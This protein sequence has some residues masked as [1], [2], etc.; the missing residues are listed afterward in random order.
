[1]R[2]RYVVGG[3][4]VVLV[5]AALAVAAT[6]LPAFGHY[7]HAY[8]RVVARSA[9]ADRSATNA[10]VVTTFD[11]RGFDTLGEEFI[12]F[13]SVVGVV[14]LLRRMRRE[15]DGEPAEADPAELEVED[16]V[17]STA[18]RWLGA[19]AVGP[20]AVLAVYII[21][22]GALTPGG[23][24]QGGV[25]LMAAALALA[26]GGQSAVLLR[27][28]RSSTPLEMAEAAGASAFVMIGF[29]GLIAS[30]VFFSNFI[31]KGTHGLLSGGVLP[32]DNIAVGLEVAGALLIVISELFDQRLRRGAG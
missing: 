21:V 4:G 23:G 28:R 1:M 7:S 25:I 9:Q 10:V 3:L 22:H 12:L 18:E 24:F 14:V 15:G 13:I 16:A 30:G 29:G 17:S 11:Y 5:V 31:D 8:G 19:A 2:P 27:L 6:D 26:L 20:V 32:L